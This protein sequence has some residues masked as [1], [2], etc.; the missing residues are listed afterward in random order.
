[1]MIPKTSKFTQLQSMEMYSVLVEIHSA[2]E[3]KKNNK[4]GL[5]KIFQYEIGWF[6][7][8]GDLLDKINDPAINTGVKR[9]K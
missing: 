6:V 7:G 1:M 8:I 5:N 4:G 9:L 3:N 2:L